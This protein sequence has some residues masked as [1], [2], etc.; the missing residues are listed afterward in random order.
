MNA[1]SRINHRR[2]P[3]FSDVVEHVLE[4]AN[5]QSVSAQNNRPAVLLTR[6]QIQRSLNAMLG[7]EAIVVNVTGPREDIASLKIGTLTTEDFISSLRAA[8]LAS[9]GL[10]LVESEGC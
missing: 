10:D 5:N 7:S 9:E 8:M 4:A 2:H 6:S 3:L 1:Q